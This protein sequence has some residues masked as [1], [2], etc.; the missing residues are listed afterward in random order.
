MTADRCR[1]SDHPAA[2]HAELLDTFGRK[3]FPEA[4]CRSDPL[5]SRAELRN[6]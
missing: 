6:S 3:V 1:L 2:S 5:P 4:T